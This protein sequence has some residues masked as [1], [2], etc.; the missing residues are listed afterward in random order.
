MIILSQTHRYSKQTSGGYQR[1]EEGQEGENYEVQTTRY[2]IR[3]TVKD[4]F[5][6]QRI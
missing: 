2:K 1:E 5:I 6:A 3:K 4:I